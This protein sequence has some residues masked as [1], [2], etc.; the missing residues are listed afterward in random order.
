MF[1]LIITNNYFL[2]NLLFHFFNSYVIIFIVEVDIMNTISRGKIYGF[3]D[4]YTIYELYSPQG[5]RYHMCLPNQD[6]SIYKMYLGFPTQDTD[7]EPTYE[8]KNE[9]E[10]IYDM[11]YKINSTSVYVFC[12]IDYKALAE[13]ANDNDNLLYNQLLT[14]IHDVTRDAFS[15]LNRN[16]AVQVDQTIMAIKQTPSDIK[17]IN[18]LD[19]KLNGF[20]DGVKLESIEKKYRQLMADESVTIDYNNQRQVQDV[21]VRKLIKPDSYGFMTMTFIVS[22]LLISIM[23]G[24]FISLMLINK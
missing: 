14:G 15:L 1:L 19:L 22:I 5:T 23:L 8:I 4:E 13:A 16:N 24:I 2:Y 20:L 18:W 17:F 3:K 6:V 7:N 11:L 10:R 21:K 9:I 12:D